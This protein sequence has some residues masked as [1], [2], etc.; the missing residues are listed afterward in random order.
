MNNGGVG[1]LLDVC[2]HAAGW[3]RIFHIMSVLIRKGLPLA[4]MRET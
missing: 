1:F 2:H 3:I 4:V